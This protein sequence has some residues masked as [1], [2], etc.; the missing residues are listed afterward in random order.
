M[1]FFEGNLFIPAIQSVREGGGRTMERLK[2]VGE[3]GRGSYGTVWL[4]Q[5]RDNS[6]TRSMLVLKCVSLI[7]QHLTNS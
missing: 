1:R 7:Q 4:V 6:Q 2:V 3:V 5:P